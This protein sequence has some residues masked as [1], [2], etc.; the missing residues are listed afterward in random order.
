MNQ[1]L[2]KSILDYDAN[3]GEFIWK[4]QRGNSAIGKVAGC[5]D[6]HGY[7]II[8]YDNKGYK[9]HRLAWLYMTGNFPVKNIDHIDRNK[10]NNK[11]SNL[12][13]V[14]R[15]ENNMN[16]PLAKNNVSG[17]KGVFKYRNKWRAVC[18]YESNQYYLG[19]FNTKE[20]AA[21]SYSNFTTELGVIV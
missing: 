21:N 9:A 11:F 7:V 16:R 12:R 18:R 15:S 14:S 17:H 5:I 19:D 13:E 3:S 4:I 10:S 1:D 8:R 6:K 2:L 20:E